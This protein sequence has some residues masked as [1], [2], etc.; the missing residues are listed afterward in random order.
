MRARVVWLAVVVAVVVVVVVGA[1]LRVARAGNE[2]TFLF[3]DHASLMAGAVTPTANGTGAVWYNPAGLGVGSRNKLELSASVFM[4]QIR[5]IPD[6]LQVTWSG[7]E[8]KEPIQGTRVYIVPTS[9]VWVRQI[10]GFTIGLGVFVTQQDLFRFDGAIKRGPGAPGL[11]LDMAGQLSGESLRYHLGASFGRKVTP[12]LRIGGSVFIVYEKNTEFRKLFGDATVEGGPYTSTFLQRLVDAESSRLSVELVAGLQWEL[13]NCIVG[14]VVR[15]PRFTFWESAATDNST[16]VVSHGDGVPTV[17]ITKVTHDPIGAY[18]TGPTMPPRFVLGL[19]RRT[20]RSELA[21][22]VEAR[23][24]LFNA[25]LADRWVVNG[26]AGFMFAVGQKN[27]LG[28]GVFTDRS[29]QA[30][31]QAF[32]AYRVDYYGVTAGWK[33]D[34]TVKLHGTERSRNIV[35]STTAALRY[36]LGVGESTT[37]R[38]DYSHAAADG[39]VDRVD[40]QRVNVLFHEIS[41][42]LG[43]ALEF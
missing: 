27:T 33:R 1:P 23:P 36:A 4:L 34:S 3:G 12:R 18:G 9:L 31:P 19:A 42:Y 29:G 11:D 17:T 38:F 6:M 41:L 8:L 25:A 10:R 43:T 20:V 7:G 35:F 5:P 15:S 40:D 37:I 2:D 24:P 26:R 32:P 14:A 28:F 30:T 22:E 39:L 21:F 16:S 13:A